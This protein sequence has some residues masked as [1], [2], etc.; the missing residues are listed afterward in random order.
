MRQTGNFQENE[1]ANG[2]ETKGEKEML[3]WVTFKIEFCVLTQRQFS[4]R[5]ISGHKNVKNS[6]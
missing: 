2:K 4:F 1:E 5:E 6:N 3:C